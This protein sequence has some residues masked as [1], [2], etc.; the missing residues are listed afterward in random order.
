MRV[1]MGLAAS[2]VVIATL[3]GCGS[4]GSPAPRPLASV[5]PQ[6]L[7][8]AKREC[9]IAVQ[10]INA[11]AGP[12]AKKNAAGVIAAADE[13]RA[14]EPTIKLGGKGTPYENVAADTL[15]MLGLI[16]MV[17]DEA[18]SYENG[19]APWGDVTGQA[20]TLSGDFRNLDSACAAAHVTIK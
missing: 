9:K 3:A 8:A 16:A 18:V 14:D 4:V 13:A 17:G 7:A 15:V 2:G 20:S 12:L 1:G 10:A 11:V 5:S 6:A 19:Q